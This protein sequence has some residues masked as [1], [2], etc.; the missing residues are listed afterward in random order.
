MQTPLLILHK[1]AGEAGRGGGE[2]QVSDESS[3]KQQCKFVGISELP[4]V[5]PKVVRALTFSQFNL[6]P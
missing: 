6:Q 5:K 3:D 4:S 1:M 2:G